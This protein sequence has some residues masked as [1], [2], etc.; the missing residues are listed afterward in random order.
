MKRILIILVGSAFLVSLA[1]EAQRFQIRPLLTSSPQDVGQAAIEWTRNNYVILSGTPQVVLARPV[2][3]ADLPALGLPVTGFVGEEPPLMLVIL[4]GD[5]DVSNMIGAG[6]ASAWNRRV[7]YIAYVFD[8]RAGVPTLTMTSL[9]GGDFRQAL[10]DPTLPD[11]GPRSPY[12][13][14]TSIQPHQ[15]QHPSPVTPLPYGAVVPKT[16]LTNPAPSA[17]VSRTQSPGSVPVPYPGP[18]QGGPEPTGSPA[19][20]P[21]P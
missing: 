9:R 21:A 11:D 3:A 6:L 13:T 2:R 5:F 17:R 14:T 20:Y 4:K 18:G 16:P 1:Y 12:P 8:L 7:A 10:N 15:S 19:T